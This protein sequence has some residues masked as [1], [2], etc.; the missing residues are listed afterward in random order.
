MAVQTKTRAFALNVKELG[1]RG[2]FCGY[3]SVFDVID[4]YQ[5][6]VAPGA[7]KNTLATWASKAAM[8]PLLWQHRAGEPIGPFTRMEEDKKGLYVEA[9]LLVDDIARAREAWALLKAKVI[10]GM[11]IG[12]R[13]M[14][15]GQE[16]DSRAG[17][18]ILT[19]V[20]LWEGSLATFPAN[21]AA[22]V[23][24]VKGR[25]FI[26]RIRGVTTRGELPHVRDF[27]EAMREVF[28]FSR[29]QAKALAS[30]GL[31]QLQREADSKEAT[32]VD[33]S[34]AT[35]AVDAIK[36]FAT[37]KSLLEESRK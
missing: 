2:T 26:E 31:G 15:G 17:L 16:Y 10:S 34:S 4:S 18:S 28:A 11:S 27:E 1:Q 20:D 9:Q 30:L 8:P 12:F 32:A 33:V 35:L 22:V 24:T 7:F 19:D 29:S 21:E 37:F 25:E 14:P 23:E 36:Q 13:V 3:L 5:E 6:V